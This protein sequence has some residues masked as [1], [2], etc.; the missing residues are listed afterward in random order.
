MRHIAK[1]DDGTGNWNESIEFV[2]DGALLRIIV[3]MPDGS[4]VERFVTA[5]DVAA[6]VRAAARPQT[7]I[8]IPYRVG[9]VWIGTGTEWGR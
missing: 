9:D 2:E 7:P 8:T 5:D 1:A 6:I 4:T 3:A